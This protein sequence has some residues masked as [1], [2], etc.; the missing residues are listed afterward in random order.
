MQATK[1]RI[2]GRAKGLLRPQGKKGLIRLF[3]ALLVLGAA[4]GINWAL[5]TGGERGNTMLDATLEQLE[6]SVRQ[7]PQNPQA[8]V[9]VAIAYAA[10]GYNDDAI[11]QFQEALKLEESN[12]TALIGLGQTLLRSDRPDEALEPL[13]QVVEL[14]KD[15]PFRRTLEQLEAVYY[16]LGII[17]TQKRDYQ[18]ATFYLGEALDINP[19]DADAWYML[20]HAQQLSGELEIALYSY[21]QATLFVPDFVEAYEGLAEIYR[22]MEDEGGERYAKGMI[23]LAAGSFDRAVSELRKAAAAMPDKAEVHQGLG[24]ALEGQDHIQDALVSYGRALELDPTLMLARL[25]TQRLE[26]Q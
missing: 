23:R 24:L 10:R 7:D 21:E 19:V 1:T 12:Q 25:A 8:R 26:G 2:I 11:T 18:Q 3:I 14:N 13:L 5:F 4:I 22:Q 15:N 20:G 16:D 6:S 17:Y 9:A